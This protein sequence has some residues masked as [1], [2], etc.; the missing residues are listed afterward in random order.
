[1]SEPIHPSAPHHLPSFI[2]APGD[3]DVMMVVVGIF[4][5]VAVLAVGNFYLHLHSLP[6]RMAHKSQKFQFEIVAVLGLLSL[7]THNHLFWVIGLFLAMIDL[8]DFSTPLRRIAGSVEK[9]AGVPPEQ[10]P[11]EPQV[12]DAA[13]ADEAKAR[14]EK[15]GGAK[16]EV[17]SHA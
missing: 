12:G 9:M 16:S 2:T 15:A 14:I 11:T 3:T 4:L 8:P 7:F 5:I 6:E 13:H 1:M 10:D 17:H